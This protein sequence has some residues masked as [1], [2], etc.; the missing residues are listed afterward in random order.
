MIKRLAICVCSLLFLATDV[1]AQEK[2][3]P[4]L[5]KGVVNVGDPAKIK[6]V[7]AREDDFRNAYLKLDA[8]L[9]ADLY[10]DDYLQLVSVKWCCVA[11]KERQMEALIEHRDMQPPNPLT[12]ITN[13]QV[14][15]HVHGNVA[16]VTGVQTVVG[17]MKPPTP[18]RV[19]YMNVWELKDGKW[20]IIGGSKKML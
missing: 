9:A 12:S 2:E 1:G 15:V 16:I 7:L 20:K 17:S 19:L 18:S 13:E 10:D 14:V 11:N 8:K 4:P 3:L 6:A 5:P